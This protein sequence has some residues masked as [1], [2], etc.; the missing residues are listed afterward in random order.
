MSKFGAST[1]KER[2][3]QVASV[4]SELLDIIDKILSTLGSDS[5]QTIYWYLEQKYELRREN[6][7]SRLQSFSEAMLQIFGI[8]AS[9]LLETRIIEMVGR[10]YPEFTY[11]PK[12]E[13]PNL[14]EFVSSLKAD[15]ESKPKT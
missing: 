15:L 5:K 4:D 3:Q 10:K 2:K 7:P 1:V 12:K 6:I 14:A 13:S 8:P 9:K 11:V